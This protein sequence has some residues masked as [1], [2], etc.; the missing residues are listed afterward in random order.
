MNALIRPLTPEQQNRLSRDLYILLEKQVKSYHKSRH[1]GE[2]SSVPAEI[3]Q[4]LLQSVWYTL[5]NSGGYTPDLPLDLQL[6]RGQESLKKRLADSKKLYRLVSATAPDF[7]T[8]FHWDTVEALGRWLETYD[9]LHFAHRIPEML[10]Y[11]LLMPVP[12]ELKGLDYGLFYLNTLWQ[13]N[14]ILHSL[15]GEAVE[16]LHLRCPPGWWDGPQ[17][18][19]EQPLFN[20]L[21]LAV[22]GLPPGDLTIS[23]SQEEALLRLCA[24]VDLKQLLFQAAD[25][26]REFL[27]LPEAD[28]LHA[29]AAQ[30][31][32]RLEIAL[33]KGELSTVFI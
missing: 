25:R 20:A 15:P 26:V 7:R 28:T 3:A 2:N 4:E 30:L 33:A 10:D 1:M 5:E 29:A 6:L 12:E 21:A 18:F 22:L 23:I 31:K 17:N 19:C 27:D 16:N 8:D 11:P 14:Q 13:E 9:P 32:S 24:G